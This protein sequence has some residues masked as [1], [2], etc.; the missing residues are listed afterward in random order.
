MRV[1][2]CVCVFVFVG[3]RPAVCQRPQTLAAPNVHT[4]T[5]THTTEPELVSLNLPE[6]FHFIRIDR[7]E[8]DWR[9]IRSV[10]QGRVMRDSRRRV[11]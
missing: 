5:R 1:Y 6:S 11:C 9:D 4:D 8:S 7:V 2:V 10:E 3:E